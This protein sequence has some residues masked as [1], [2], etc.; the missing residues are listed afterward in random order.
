[1]E[2]VGDTAVTAE[3]LNDK[4]SKF[5]AGC[6]ELELCL[7]P[8]WHVMLRLLN[9]GKSEILIFLQ[10]DHSKPIQEESHLF[11]FVHL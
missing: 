8:G 2:T 11:G 3:T 9:N 7:K 10:N 1:M 6:R 4:G 5:P